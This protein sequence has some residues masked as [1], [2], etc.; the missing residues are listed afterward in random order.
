MLC[1][2]G[3]TVFRQKERPRQ[4]QPVIA[5]AAETAPVT[6]ETQPVGEPAA[7]EQPAPQEQATAPESTGATT[8]AAE[9]AETVE[10]LEF[11]EQRYEIDEPVAAEKETEKANDA[12]IERLRQELAASESELE[13]MR[14][15]EEKRKY[16]A[17][18]AASSSE[19]T[20]TEIA[21]SGAEAEAA[22]MTSEQPTED[23]AQ[24]AESS[25]PMAP[26]ARPD[27]SSLPGMPSETTVYFD[28]DQAVVGS[29][30]E[31]VIVANANFLKEN[32]DLKVEIQGNCDERGSREYNIAL[33]QRRAERVKQALELL[34]VDGARIDTVSF[35]S[36]KPA[37]FGH[38]EASWR[39]NRRADLVYTY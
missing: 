15:E 16:S 28:F 30:Y 18:E 5:V 24:L 32:P 7:S 26:K 29:Q 11:P 21:S 17:G 34:G 13:K 37:A 31:S 4:T 23:N 14:A 10:P 22:P 9:Q 27:I 12:E 35:G 3:I 1:V 36:E 39:L 33:G 8:G 2:A 20:G 6:A 25:A 19:S 38:D